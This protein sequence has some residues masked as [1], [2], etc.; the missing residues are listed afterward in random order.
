MPKTKPTCLLSVVTAA[1]LVGCGTD[2]RQP[3][4]SQQASAAPSPVAA[5]STKKAE[6]NSAA[7]PSKVGATELTRLEY[8]GLVIQYQGFTEEQMKAYLEHMLKF[9]GGK[10]KTFTT[11]ARY[12]Y[13][14]KLAKVGK[15]MKIVREDDFTRIWFPI[16][17][18]RGKDRLH[19]GTLAIP[20]CHSLIKIDESVRGK[21]AYA[22]CNDDCT[23]VYLATDDFKK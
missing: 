16:E 20:L 12:G 19:F 5:T 7:R 11:G 14:V 3:K 13:Q 21:V 1:L 2:E 10:G 23:V 9:Y 18:K 8:L 17:E 6:K 15:G 4:R 22:F